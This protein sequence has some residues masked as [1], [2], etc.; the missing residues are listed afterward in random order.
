MFVLFAQNLINKSCIA[1]LTRETQLFDGEDSPVLCYEIRLTFQDR[2]SFDLFE[3][4][5]VLQE[6]W[7]NKRWKELQKLLCGE[8]GIS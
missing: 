4:F 1:T 5:T 7:F 8:Q 6:Y 2:I 3:K